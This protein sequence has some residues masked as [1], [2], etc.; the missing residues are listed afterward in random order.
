MKKTN[1]MR[2]QSIELVKM[3]TLVREVIKVFDSNK[4]SE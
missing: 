1:E 2:V 4:K 3:I